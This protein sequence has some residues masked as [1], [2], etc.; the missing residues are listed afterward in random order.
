[1]PASLTKTEFVAFD[2]ETTGLSAE[3]ARI[4]EIGAVRFRADGEVLGQF[5]QLINPECRIPAGV[6][7]IH[8]ITDAM[9]ADQP[10]IADV[11]PA[12]IEFFGD[13]RVLLLAHNAHFDMR[14]LAA[15]RVDRGTA[16]HLIRWST[17]VLWHD[18]GCPCRTT[19]WS[20]S[21]GICG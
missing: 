1:M 15:A 20:P 6:T 16:I 12:L 14:F 5:A 19:S 10:V 2:L 13:P 7:A 9:V 11:L 3:T 4:V 18:G 21:D 17:R 8:G